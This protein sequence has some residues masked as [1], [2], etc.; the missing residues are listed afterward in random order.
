[1]DNG[2]AINNNLSAYK[3]D[4]QFVTPKIVYQLE[5]RHPWIEDKPTCH[6]TPQATLIIFVKCKLVKHKGELIICNK[7][8]RGKRVRLKMQTHMLNLD[9]IMEKSKLQQRVA[10]E[11]T[12]LM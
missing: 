4:W 2:V 9:K 10:L 8:S 6:K 7:I 1:M 5:Q 11:S 3:V 12:G